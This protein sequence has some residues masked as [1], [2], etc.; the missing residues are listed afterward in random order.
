MLNTKDITNFIT[1]KPKNYYIFDIKYNKKEQKCIDDFNINIIKNFSF[2]GNITNLIDQ[3]NLEIFLTEIGQC[4]MSCLKGM[5]SSAS[6]TDSNLNTNENITII[7]EIIYKL[8]KKIIKS[9]MTDY[10]W[11]SIRINLPNNEFKIRRWH[12]DGIF[13][14]N[15]KNALQA[16]FVTVL[17]GPGTIFLK[18]EKATEIYN[19]LE[20]YIRNKNKEKLIDKN[21]DIKTIIEIE[22]KYRPLYEKALKVIKE[23]QL[24]NNQGL[25]FIT[26]SGNSDLVKHPF[27]HSEPNIDKPRF[28]I[29]ILP[30]SQEDIEA[31]KL[32]WKK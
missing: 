16:K 25:I 11:I 19:K 10:F 27:I 9:F 3:N 18:N 32:R 23:Y 7:K 12:Y 21:T 28:F 29:S 26:N 22:K 15:N 30:G 5:Q 13:F 14:I 17:K 1:N 20:T 4:N 24:K 2:F 6:E 8:I 31:L